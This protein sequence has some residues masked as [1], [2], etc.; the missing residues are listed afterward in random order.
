MILEK[1]MSTYKN[2]KHEA[3]FKPDVSSSFFAKI[4]ELLDFFRLGDDLSV[5]DRLSQLFL[6][7]ERFS[8]L[9]L[10]EDRL[11]RHLERDRYREEEGR[12]YHEESE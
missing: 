8:S 7:D 3:I 1:L 11:S 5:D 9:L 6:G 12:S 2:I 10:G 4:F